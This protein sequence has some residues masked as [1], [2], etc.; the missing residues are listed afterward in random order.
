[1]AQSA[2]S[3]R[4]RQLHPAT[5]AHE[6]NAIVP[7]SWFQKFPWLHF[8]SDIG[9]VICF[10]C[11][12]AAR[13]NLADM[14]RCADDAFTVKGFS[15]WKKAI[16]QFTAHQ[17]TSTHAISHSNL[18][19]LATGDDEAMAHDKTIECDT[20]STMRHVPQRHRRYRFRKTNAEAVPIIAGVY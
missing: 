1:M 13:A 10:T 11:S 14:V 5:T 8:D 3:A 9:G 16:E 2:E 12:K 6:V 4:E 20:F 19:F 18:N 17:K 15:N 7:K